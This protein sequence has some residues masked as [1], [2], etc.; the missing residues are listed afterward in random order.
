[1]ADILPSVPS[2]RLIRKRLPRIFP[3]GTESRAF[4]T[5]QI[6]VKTVS[7]MLYVGAIEGS[8]RWVRPDQVTKMTDRQAAKTDDGSRQRWTRESMSPGRMRDIR[9]RWYAVNTRESIRDETLRM[10]LVLSGAVVERAGVPTTSARPRYALQRGFAGL[11]H[12]PGCPTEHSQR[13]PKN[14]R[15]AT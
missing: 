4:L 1:M 3:E 5:R 10:G 12:K 13:P 14:G 15:R 7:V 9:G 2:L 8:D 6:A 11:F